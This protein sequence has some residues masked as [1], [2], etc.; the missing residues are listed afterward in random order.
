[1]SMLMLAAILTFDCYKQ[2]FGQAEYG[3]K[4]W[5]IRDLRSVEAF[6]GRWR[7][8]LQNALGAAGGSV[9]P[10]VRSLP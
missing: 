2:V 10:P 9:A 3:P 6:V 5:V 1:M 8:F 4:F 7:S